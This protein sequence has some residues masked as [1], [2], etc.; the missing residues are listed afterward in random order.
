[1]IFVWIVIGFVQAAAGVLMGAFGY[2]HRLPV[3]EHVEGDITAGLQME[4]HGA[5]S[6]W[7]FLLATPLGWLSLWLFCEGLLRVLAA[8]MQVPFSTLPV[9][10]VRL[11]LSLRRPPELPPDV[12][13]RPRPDEILIDSARDYDWH[14]LSTVEVDGA[15]HAVQCEQGPPGRPHRYR[16][17]PIAHDH[18]VRTVIRYPLA[19]PAAAQAQE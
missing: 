7:F 2:L 1:V 3:I 6:L 11:G 4:I 16:L 14:A 18:V 5:A 13:R 12:V 10:L 9:G 15:L 19:A 8:S 17:R